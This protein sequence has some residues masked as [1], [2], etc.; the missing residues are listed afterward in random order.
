MDRRKRIVVTSI[1]A[2]CTG[3][4]MVVSGI[5]SIAFIHMPSYEF[6]TIRND[7]LKGTCDGLVI[8]EPVPTTESMSLITDRDIFQCWCYHHKIYLEEPSLNQKDHNIRLSANILMWTGLSLVAV[9]FIFLSPVPAWIYKHSSR[10][11]YASV[12]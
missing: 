12:S 5:V 3:F 7:T 10:R 9:G 11:S 6:C 2:I 8:I 4:L 1:V